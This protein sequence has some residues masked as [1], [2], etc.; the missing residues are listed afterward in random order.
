MLDAGCGTGALTLALPEALRRKGFE[1]KSLDAFD[2]TP[3]MLG[4]CHEKCESRGELS[5]AFGE[6]GFPRMDFRAFPPA[7]SHLVTWGH[8]IEAPKA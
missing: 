6:A 1:T 8:I 5:A 7:A 2:L 4:M 3:A